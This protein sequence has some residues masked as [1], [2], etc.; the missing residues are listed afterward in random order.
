MNTPTAKAINPN[1]HGSNNISLPLAITIVTNEPTDVITICRTCVIA[2]NKVANPVA[3][4][5]LINLL[6][7]HTANEVSLYAL[8]KCINTPTA[9]AIKPNNHGSNKISFPEAVTIPTNEVTEVITVVNT[10]VIDANN[11]A[12]ITP[13]YLPLIFFNLSMMTL[14]IY[15]LKAIPKI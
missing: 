12:I 11:D 8:A 5:K 4:V 13:F 9:K 14:K 7:D 2:A 3:S 15:K 10:V 6:S 1:S